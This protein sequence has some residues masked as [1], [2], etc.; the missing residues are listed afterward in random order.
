MHQLNLGFDNKDL[1][2]GCQI[3]EYEP[4]KFRL[5]TPLDSKL[6]IVAANMVEILKSVPRSKRDVL[7]LTGPV[8]PDIYL[9]AMSI[10]GPAFKRVDRLDGKR[11]TSTTIPHPPPHHNGEPE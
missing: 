8:P 6:V 1:Y 3:T 9:T 7:V 5:D 11:K 4:G 10:L 2:K